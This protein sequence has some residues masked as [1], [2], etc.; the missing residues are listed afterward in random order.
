MSDYFLNEAARLQGENATL[1]QQLIACEALRERLHRV[2]RDLHSDATATDFNEH[3]ESYKRAG[4]TLTESPSTAL[5]EY[6]WPVKEA[7]EEISGVLIYEQGEPHLNKLY[8]R[9]KEALAL[10]TALGKES[11]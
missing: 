11:H 5:A 1:R 9:S 7:L 8:K 4:E 2:L 10:L 6:L 3:W